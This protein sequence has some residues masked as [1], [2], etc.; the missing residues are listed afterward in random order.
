MEFSFDCPKSSLSLGMECAACCR[1]RPPSPSPYFRKKHPGRRA[2]DSAAGAGARRR[3]LVRVHVF[4]AERS[5]RRQLRDD[6][7]DHVDVLSL[8]VAQFQEQ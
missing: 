3:A 7:L 6:L 8:F 2:H 4:K 1:P 5:F